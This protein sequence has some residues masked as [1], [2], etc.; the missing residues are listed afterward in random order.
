MINISTRRSIDK[1][2]AWAEERED[3][4]R[5]A[6]RTGLALA[7]ASHKAAGL[8]AS[9]VAAADGNTSTTAL[10]ARAAAS[11]ASAAQA[12][13]ALAHH[14]AVRKPCIESINSVFEAA[15][16]AFAAAVE[17]A[18]QASAPASQPATATT[19]PAT[20]PVAAGVNGLHAAAAASAEAAEA[21]SIAAAVLAAHVVAVAGPES[22]AAARV[23]ADLRV[24]CAVLVKARAASLQVLPQPQKAQMH[25][26]EAAKQA[27]AGQQALSAIVKAATEIGLLC[28]HT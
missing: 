20:S 7:D 16:R 4:Q 28:A 17:A 19:P 14:L 22:P 3:R 27:G 1:A 25:A 10:L 24:A 21:T 18:K 23:K 13:A 5:R 2:R 15:D 9:S 26:R 12:Q 6:A 11:E 8:L